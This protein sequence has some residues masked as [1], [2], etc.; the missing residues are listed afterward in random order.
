MKRF[1]LPIF[2][3]V[4][5]SGY[6]AVAQT[7][8]P[9]PQELQ[10]K[11]ERLSGDVERLTQD[12]LSLKNK[13]S[14]LADELAKN[15]EE[16]VKLSSKNNVHEDLQRLAE[17]IQEVDSARVKGNQDIADQ[18]RKIGESVREAARAEA[19]PKSRPTHIEEPKDTTP[20]HY[21]YVI[22][23][24]DTLSSVVLAYNKEFKSKGM[25][26]ISIQQVLEA[27]PKL[28]PNSVPAGKK[29][30]IPMPSSK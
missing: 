10:E 8:A 30:I 5:L 1:F 15:H 7:P 25:K 16:M 19:R 21:E 14:A 20:D 27:N 4:F 6:L 22:A 28:N 24:G 26:T 18:I 29:I 9:S 13:I 23:P 2:S 3:A 12:N 11:V 17:K